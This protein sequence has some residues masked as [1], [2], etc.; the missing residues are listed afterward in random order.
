MNAAPEIVIEAEHT[1]SN[2][3]R[4]PFCYRELFYF[5]ARRD[6]LVRYNQAMI[7]I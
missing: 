7:G 1:D 2:Y 6:V 3:W 4:H 5:L